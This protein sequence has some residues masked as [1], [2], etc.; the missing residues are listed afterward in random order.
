MY[1]LKDYEYALKLQST[2]LILFIILQ[3]Q[4]IFKLKILYLRIGTTKLLGDDAM[5]LVS[6]SLLLIYNARA[7]AYPKR[8]FSNAGIC[9][10]LQSIRETE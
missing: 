3:N 9:S 6:I 1:K 5:P 8:E 10:S 2:K 7:M 4:S